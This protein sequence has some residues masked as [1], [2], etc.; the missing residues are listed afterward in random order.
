MRALIDS[1]AGAKQPRCSASAGVA[2]YVA[3]LQRVQEVIFVLFLRL[4]GLYRAWSLK[5]QPFLY[6]C[7]SAS[8]GSKTLANEKGSVDAVEAAP[9]TQKPVY[10]R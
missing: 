6:A 1:D 10:K 8:S 4:M 2:L 7:E 3:A 5:N 9:S